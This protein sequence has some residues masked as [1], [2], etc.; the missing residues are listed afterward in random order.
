MVGSDTPGVVKMSYSRDGRFEAVIRIDYDSHSYQL[1]Y[2]NS[3]G[4]RYVKSDD[5]GAARIHR[6]YNKWIQTLLKKI[7]IPGELE[8][9]KIPSPKDKGS[10]DDGKEG[11]DK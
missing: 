9:V 4:L 1:Q 6:N 11:D 10:D 8:P 5:K 7:A 2:V 3:V